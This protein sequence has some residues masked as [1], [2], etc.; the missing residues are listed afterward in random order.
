MMVMAEGTAS[1]THVGSSARMRA[2]S[3]AAS[4]GTTSGTATAAARDLP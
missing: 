1:A 4:S 2:R 3:G